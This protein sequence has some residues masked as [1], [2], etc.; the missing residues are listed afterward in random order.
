MKRLVFAAVLAVTLVSTTALAE[1]GESGSITDTSTHIRPQDLSLMLTVPYYNGIG[2]GI[3]GRFEIPVVPDGFIPALNDEFSI[4]PGLGLGYRSYGYVGANYDVFD[5]VP[6]V[7]AM[8]SFWFSP[9]FRAY[10]AIGL[11]YD[12]GIFTG[13]GITGTTASFFYWDIPAVGI[14]Y[15]F[16]P[17]LALRAELGV[18]GLKG[19][20][21]FSF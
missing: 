7:Y 8:W 3:V 18:Q 2:I 19:G 20:L 9:K 10:G 5:I 12:I 4:E 15:Y 11:G 16:Q 21:S 14:Y 1:G 6:Q 17:N 13:T